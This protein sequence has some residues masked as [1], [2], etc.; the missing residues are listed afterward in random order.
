MSNGTLRQETQESRNA[1][2]L[3]IRL[4]ISHYNL[5]HHECAAIIGV[6]PINIR[7]WLING[8]IPLQYKGLDQYASIR[9]HIRAYRSE[10]PLV[11]PNQAKPEVTL[12]EPA[13][14]DVLVRA[15]AIAKVA[16]LD[17]DPE[18]K[19]KLLNVLL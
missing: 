4:F 13:G 16:H 3:R 1:L 7:R 6:N 5:S 9:E 18:V 8:N 12:D 17:I 10:H 11:K 2:M 15:D 19:R 14:S